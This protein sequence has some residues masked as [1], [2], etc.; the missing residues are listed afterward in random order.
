M[1]NLLRHHRT[2]QEANRE[3]ASCNLVFLKSAVWWWIMEFISK[4]KTCFLLIRLQSPF[5]LLCLVFIFFGP[6][7]TLTHV[8]PCMFTLF[9]PCSPNATLTP[10]CHSSPRRVNTVT[11]Q[12]ADWRIITDTLPGPQHGRQLHTITKPSNGLRVMTKSFLYGGTQQAFNGN[13]SHAQKNEGHS[14]T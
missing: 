4:L 11:F 8:R 13:D 1:L 9:E 5:L 7:L 14:W 3:A 6:S 2:H 10:F 12:R